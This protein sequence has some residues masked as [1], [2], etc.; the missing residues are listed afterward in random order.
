MPRDDPVKK[1]H[2]L[3]NFST[4]LKFDNA[5]TDVA[6]EKLKKLLRGHVEEEVDKVKK[7]GERNR[8]CE[9]QALEYKDKASVCAYVLVCLCASALW[10]RYNC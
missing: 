9:K 6:F 5:H 1:I 3:C 7:N 8:E 2:E 10:R 4:V